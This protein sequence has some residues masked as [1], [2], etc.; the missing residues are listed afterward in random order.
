MIGVGSVIVLISVGTG[1]SNAVEKQ[2]DALGSNV[3]LVSSAPTLGGPF[4]R[5]STSTSQLTLADASALQ[6]RFDAP[7]IKSVSPVV[8]A[9]GVT[10]TYNGA[11]YS[12]SSFSGT[13]PSYEQAR[14][15]T[16]AEGSW[17][18]SAD[19][20]AHSRVLVVGPTVVSELFG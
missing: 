14:D 15:Y 11:T 9:N 7:D 5:R 20:I 10:L 6:N 19:E 13:T 3:L 1:S 18:T 2:I 8:N 17:F 16:T 12:P 4:A